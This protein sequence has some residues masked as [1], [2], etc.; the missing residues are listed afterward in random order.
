MIDY[1]QVE[2]EMEKI[3]ESI[4]NIANMLPTCHKERHVSV[5]LAETVYFLDIHH[6]MLRVDCLFGV[7][8]F[9]M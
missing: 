9:L 2:V 8:H 7:V 6:R 5:I 1:Q 3:E 4:G